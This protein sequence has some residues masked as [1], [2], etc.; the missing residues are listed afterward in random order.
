MDNEKGMQSGLAL[1]CFERDIHST[2]KK[3]ER[4]DIASRNISNSLLRIISG[5]VTADKPTS[6]EAKLVVSLCDRRRKLVDEPGRLQKEDF[7]RAEAPYGG[8]LGFA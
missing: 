1:E 4:N 5:D 2:A 8:L 7:S 6:F 3:L